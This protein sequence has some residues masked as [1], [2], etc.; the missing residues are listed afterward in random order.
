MCHRV[1]CDLHLGVYF[2]ILTETEH[3]TKS[4]PLARGIAF[5]RWPIFKFVSFLEYLV[6]FQAVFETEQLYRSCRMIF[7]MFLAFLIFDPN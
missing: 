4:I 2:L 5:A 7:G 6:F 3:F 1:H